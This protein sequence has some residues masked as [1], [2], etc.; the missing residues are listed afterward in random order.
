MSFWKKRD[1]KTTEV[2]PPPPMRFPASSSVAMHT[3]TERIKHIHIF[4]ICE[5]VNDED[6]NQHRENIKNQFKEGV[7]ILPS[8]IKYIGTVPRTGGKP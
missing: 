3:D 5:V 4:S 2:A 1:T 6:L 7:V 8:F